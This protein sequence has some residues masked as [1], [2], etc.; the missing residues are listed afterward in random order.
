MIIGIDFI[1]CTIKILNSKYCYVYFLGGAVNS[2][3]AG[4]YVGF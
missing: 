1:D 3:I 4:I 2:R